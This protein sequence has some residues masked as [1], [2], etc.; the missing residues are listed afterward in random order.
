M[1]DRNPNDNQEV[2]YR[3]NKIILGFLRMGNERR[4]VFCRVLFGLR[5]G[6]LNK[7][8]SREKMEK[9][10]EKKSKR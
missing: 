3:L 7:K 8:D 6:G 9:V 1:I 5:R 10:E 2:D 4:R